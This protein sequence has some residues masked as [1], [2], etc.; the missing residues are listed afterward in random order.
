MISSEVIRQELEG[1]LAQRQY[2]AAVV[3]QTATRGWVARKTWSNLKRSL[4]LQRK[5]RMQSRSDTRYA[6]EQFRKYYLA[7]VL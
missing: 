1:L 6:A 7:L 3:L 4:E 2:S 5:A